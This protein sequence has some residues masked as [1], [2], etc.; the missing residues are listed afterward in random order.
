MKDKTELL[1]DHYKETYSIIKE[2]IRDRN[3]FFL[4]FFIIMSIQFLFAVTPD[5][6]SS[7]IISIIYTSYDIDISSQI[8]VI[9]SLLWLI[10]LY[11][12]MRYYQCSVYIERQYKYIHSLEGN[13]SALIDN[14][15]D[16]E[17]ADYLSFYP[18]MNDMIDVMYKWVFPIIYC[19][20]ITIKIVGEFANEFYCCKTVFD[21]VIFISCFV[22][23]ILYLLFLHGNK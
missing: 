12:T 21:G 13:I 2:N 14:K 23:T 1:Y 3:K 22:L 16:R 20:V 8:T 6:I 7:I 10:L 9:Q 15:F 11:F 4:L 17:S 18:K 19:V 5:S